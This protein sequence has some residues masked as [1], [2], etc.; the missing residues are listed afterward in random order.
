MKL[1]IIIP[2][3]NVKL[4]IVKCVKSLLTQDFNDY[5]LII[6]DDGSRDE[7]I[8]LVEETFDDEKIVIIH[9]ENKG[10]SGARNTGLL[11]ARGEFVWFFD[12]DDWCDELILN[13]IQQQLSNDI[14]LLYFNK[15]YLE[16]ENET[17]ILS[18]DYNFLSGKDLSFNIYF[19][20]V[21]F[22]IYRKSFL[23]ENKLCFLE[24]VYHEDVLFTPIALYKANKID[25]YSK[26]VY[27]LLRRSGSISQTVNPKRCY[28]L[29]KIL[30]VLDEFANNEVSV[31]DK[32]RWGH[33]IANEVNNLLMLSRN[34]DVSV[35]R[36]IMQY[37]QNKVSYMQYL[38]HD[39][40]IPTKVLGILHK[41]FNINIVTSYNYLYGLRYNRLF[42][43]GIK[44]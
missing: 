20:P 9:Q 17:T 34:C 4:Y 19:E 41:Y 2:V 42:G 38:I 11:H 29:M 32:Y 1:S 5:E 6:I 7:S 40:K 33:C 14:D 44:Y 25:S 3:Y 10:L 8:L 31:K 13:S 16:K 23:L 27:H 36:D 28:D 30:A 35:Q 43:Y 39:I 12:S 37:F 26:P 24:G 21:Q 18:H 15:F 22:Y